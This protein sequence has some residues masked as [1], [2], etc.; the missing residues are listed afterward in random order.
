VARANEY[1]QL[2]QPW[3]LAKDPAARMTLEH[4]LASLVRQLARQAVYLAPFMPDKAAEL[5]R[6]LGAPG[7]V[8]TTRFA[9]VD[10]MDPT[11]WRVSKGDPLFPRPEAP[12]P[13][14]A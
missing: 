10:V 2:Q 7:D 5:W 12:T 8:G 6:R 9:D 13:A 14:G 4:V 3:A 1:V 11:G